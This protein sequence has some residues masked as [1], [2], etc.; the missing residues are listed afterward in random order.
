MRASHLRPGIRGTLYHSGAFA[1]GGVRKQL[2][3]E[4]N[5]KE[6]NKILH[7]LLLCCLEMGSM[8]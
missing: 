5:R 8:N 6:K 2:C 7:Y 1:A 3:R 4:K